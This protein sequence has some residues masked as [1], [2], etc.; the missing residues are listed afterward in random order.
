MID[1]V[2]HELKNYGGRPVKIMEV[3]GTHTASIFK[4]G[5][6]TIISPRIQ[7]ISGPGCPVC[8]TSSAYIDELT[9]YSLKENHCVLT[10]GDMMK[11]RGSRMSLT[12][13]KAAGGRVK[14]LYSPLTAIGEAEE[15]RRIQYV[16]A[17]VGFETTA[18]VYALLLEEILQRKIENLK[19]MTSIKTIV[20]ALSFLCEKEKAIDGFLSPGHV[21]VITGCGAYRKL[22]FQ[23]QKP[24]VIA[25]FEG[26]HILA[27]VYEI[28]LQTRKQ[29]FEVKN[30][31]ASAVT[32]EGNQ[33][34]A[35]LINRYFEAGDGL[36]RG[37][38]VIEKSALRL[39]KEYRIYDAGR[40]KE[41]REEHMPVGCKCSDVILGRINPPDCPL[42]KTA[43]T[44]LHAIGPC[45]V[46]QEGACGIWYQNF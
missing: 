25:G 5:I 21:S 27:A 38:G 45:M 35:A 9:E 37:I 39:R 19:L 15:N 43:C 20:P 42:F 32:E 11:V 28:L 14:I 4:N 41:E 46:S 29:C 22:A 16:F 33:K 31:Y 17:A 30:L 40:K 23:Y 18:P 1:Q 26:E 12:E 44:P 24:F 3:C 6:R 10:F 34:A 2:I 7:L 13:A 8:V 36:W